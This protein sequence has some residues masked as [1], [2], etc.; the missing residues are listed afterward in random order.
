METKLT[1]L[2]LYQAIADDCKITIGNNVEQNWADEMNLKVEN[3][4]KETFKL[5]RSML[6]GSEF[7]GNIKTFI[8]DYLDRIIENIEKKKI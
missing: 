2:N 3:D 5:F 4:L 1:L 7:K 8:A 6:E